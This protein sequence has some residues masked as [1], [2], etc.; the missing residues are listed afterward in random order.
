MRFPDRLQVSLLRAWI[1]MRVDLRK[2]PLWAP[3]VCVFVCVCVKVCLKD[4]E[5][6]GS[7]K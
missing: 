5:P 3:C 4:T 7:D 2:S 1:A 6:A